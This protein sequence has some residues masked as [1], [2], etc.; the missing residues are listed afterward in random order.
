MIRFRSATPAVT[1]LICSKWEWVRRA[2]ICASE[3]FSPPPP[4]G[5]G[6]GG[7][8]GV[9]VGGR[10]SG[11]GVGGSKW[12]DAAV[13]R[14]RRCPP[15]RRTRRAS[16]AACAQP[17]ARPRADGRRKRGSRSPPARV[18]EE[19]PGHYR[20][21]RRIPAVPWAPEF[22]NLSSTGGCPPRRF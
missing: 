8:G 16:A 6:G 3:G 4:A 1:A 13:C 15:A 2:M 14:G 17:A 10:G 19:D 11:W 12:P 5:G 21:V 9:G 22:P 20:T 18:G 7:G